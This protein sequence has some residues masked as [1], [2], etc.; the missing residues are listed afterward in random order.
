MSDSFPPPP[1]P[2]PSPWPP[3]PPRGQRTGLIVS[4][5]VGGGLLAATAVAALVYTAMDRVAPE[6]LE[7]LPARSAGTPSPEALA[8]EDPTA[9]PSATGTAPEEDV[10]ITKC[11]VD[12]LTKWPAAELRV[13][14]GSGSPADYVVTVEF[15]DKD[16]T[17][18][19]DG[20]AAV[21]ALDA[22]KVAK[23]KAQGLG[24]VPRGTECRITEVT[25]T[26]SVG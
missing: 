16:G 8:G 12:S 26:V 10:K 15:V 3:S 20:I 2:S 17:R 18:V 25:R 14:N 4:L 19:A 7:S 11:T 5:S 24:D 22:G 13:V 6:S 23:K 1:S 21:L 9:E